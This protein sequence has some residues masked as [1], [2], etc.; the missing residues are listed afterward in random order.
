[1]KQQIKL[2]YVLPCYNIEKYI[3]DCIVSIY[4]QGL[5]TDTFEVI[6]VNDCTPDHTRDIII[7]LQKAYPNLI[8][9]DHEKNKRVGAARNK[10]LRAAKGEYVWIVDPDD[11]LRKNAA[12]ELLSILDEN[13]LDFV[14]FG[15]SWAS[16]DLVPNDTPPFD[17]NLY[18][19]T[20]IMSGKEFLDFYKSIGRKHAELHVGCFVRVFNR[21]FLKKNNIEFP[22]VAYYEDQYFALETLLAAKRMQNIPECYY[23]Y[24]EV[25]T[26]YSH[27]PM[28]V[29][30]RASQLVMCCQMY[31]LLDK[32]GITQEM[33]D[34]V[35]EHYDCEHDLAYLK[36]HFLEYM[37]NKE[38]HEFLRLIKAELSV[39]APLIRPYKQLM[40]KCPT[41]YRIYSDIVHY[42]FVLYRK[43]KSKC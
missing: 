6:C 4:N 43:L 34:Y 1:M 28:S 5:E 16:D 31:T 14:Q 24:R 26:S 22:E 27:V 7:E 38:R 29:A 13:K 42:P 41:L 11:V 15:H 10:G 37:P 2:S 40:C 17:C 33:K 9:I 30:K 3:K 23:T 25:T 35:W 12:K 39:L 18:Q 19:K 21:N 8:L 36:T 20:D 32:Y